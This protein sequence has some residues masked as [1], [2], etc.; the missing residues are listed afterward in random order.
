M[1]L[2]AQEAVAGIG[3]DVE[4][5]SLLQESGV[6]GAELHVTWWVTGK[7]CASKIIALDSNYEGKSRVWREVVG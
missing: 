3:V 1:L 5:S 7:G 6:G 2:I 4:W